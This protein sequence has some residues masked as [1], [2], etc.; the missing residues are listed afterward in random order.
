MVV[1]VNVAEVLRTELAKPSWGRHPVALGT[2]TDPYQRA[3]GK[4]KLMPGIIEALAASGTPLSMLT[5]GTLLRR[6]LGLLAAAAETIPVDLAMSI[7]I[8]DPELQQSIEPG[9]PSATARLATVTAAREAGLVTDQDAR[10]LA[11]AWRLVSRVRNAVTLARGKP[12]DEM[13]RDSRERAAVASILGY[14]PGST[15]EMVNDYLRA[16]RLARGVVD[17]VFW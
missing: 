5:K 4:Y 16:T 11:E 13:P 9:T 12:G 6:D 2:N 8:Y 7:A 15:D 3:E 17:R 14:P 1:K 10:Q